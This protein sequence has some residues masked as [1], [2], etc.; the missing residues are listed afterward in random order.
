MENC[1][2]DFA[3]RNICFLDFLNASLVSLNTVDD[4]IK[5]G[6][7]DI[8]KMSKQLLFRTVNDS[9]L[10]K[11]QTEEKVAG[12]LSEGSKKIKVI[13]IADW[14][15]CNKINLSKEIKKDEINTLVDKLIYPKLIDDLKALKE[16]KNPILQLLFPQ[17]INNL[18]ASFELLQTM[19]KILI[20][21][22]EIESDKYSKLFLETDNQEQ[23]YKSTINT[24]TNNIKISE[25][26][27]LNY[28]NK[29]K[30]LEE[31][32]ED[33]ESKK[34][35]VYYGGDN[36]LLQEYYESSLKELQNEIKSLKDNSNMQKEYFNKKLEEELDKQKEIFEAKLK[37][38]ESNFLEQLKLQNDNFEKR[39][40]GIKANIDNMLYKNYLEI[41]QKLNDA[42][43]K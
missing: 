35:S 22:A 32:I 24:L 3:Y 37:Q 20:S 1:L 13:R 15:K 28:E 27:V 33:L 2:I 16:K 30:S 12:D 14:A 6:L 25:E 26:K 5:K 39:L 10:L 23:N 4:G 8:K 21:D 42:F 41:S 19:K 34:M 43:K 38:Q 36:F 17:V 31:T 40:D 9:N 11:Y 18:F 29:I 7:Y